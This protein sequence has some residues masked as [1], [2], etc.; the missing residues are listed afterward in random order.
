MLYIRD[1]YGL[2]GAPDVPRLC[3]VRTH[4]TLSAEEA[5]PGAWQVWWDRLIAQGGRWGEP[6]HDPAH[7]DLWERIVEG[8]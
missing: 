8:R 7:D 4:P 1:R 5:G 6:D 3:G 2:R